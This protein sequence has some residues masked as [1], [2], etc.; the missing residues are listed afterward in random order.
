MAKNFINNSDPAEVFVRTYMKTWRALPAQDLTAEGVNPDRASSD[1]F[2]LA[3]L[4]NPAPDREEY[5]LDENQ[6][7]E[8]IKN[9]L[10]KFNLE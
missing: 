2:M 1:I 7:R 5:E 4:Y 10:T 6:L 9:T 8:N 3:D